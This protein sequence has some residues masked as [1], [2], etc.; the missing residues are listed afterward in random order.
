MKILL[1]NIIL[2]SSLTKL[3]KTLGL[4]PEI[5]A[6]IAVGPKIY[7]TEIFNIWEAILSEII[8]GNSFGVDRID[9]LLRD[10]YHVGVAYGKFDHYRLIDTLRLLQYEAKDDGRSTEPAIG[11]EEGGINVAESLLLARYLMF[12]QVYFHPVRRAYDIHLKDFLLKWLPNGKFSI[13]PEE[14]L[15]VTDNEVNVAIQKSADDISSVAYKEA[16]RIVNRQH[17]K[18]LYS[19]M[20]SDFNKNPNIV[21]E[22]VTE[23]MEKYGN[24]NIK[25]DF[26]LPKKA[27]DI[28][29]VL[30]KTDERVV[31]SLERSSTLNQIPLSKFD[32]I[33][34]EPK[35][36]DQA[37]KWLKEKLDQQEK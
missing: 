31:S 2:D 33:F 18:H 3:L 1:L 11:I 23:A 15:K 32:Y 29:P 28:F 36:F 17:F 22:L 37:H 9:Y 4:Q 6:K 13:Q 10:S 20:Q 24:D 26:N 8:I 19:L 21:E 16:Q 5:I 25:R 12:S 14:L 7:K 35:I 30:L 27:P 34:A